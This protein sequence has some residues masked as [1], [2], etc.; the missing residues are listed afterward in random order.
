MDGDLR[1]LALGKWLSSLNPATAQRL[2]SKMVG[3]SV[4]HLSS[5]YFA[6]IYPV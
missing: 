1:I 2:A 6:R 4:A 3:I 5:L